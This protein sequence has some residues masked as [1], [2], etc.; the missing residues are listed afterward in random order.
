MRTFIIL[1]AL[2][3]AT[4]SAGSSSGGTWSTSADE[5]T[6]EIFVDS[7]ED[8]GGDSGSGDLS[9]CHDGSEAFRFFMSSWIFF[10]QTHY[11]TWRH[12][13]D[14]LAWSSDFEKGGDDDIYNDA[15]DFS[16]FSGHGNSWGTSFHGT[17]G[18]D[19]ASSSEAQWGNNDVE[20]VALD[21]CQVLSAT[22]R[23]RVQKANVDQGVHYVLGFETNASDVS[24]TGTRY[25]YYLDVGYT[26]ASAWIQATKDGH[27]SWAKGAYVRF[28]SEDC[29]TVSDNARSW[30]CDP[31]SDS[32]TVYN[33]WTL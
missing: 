5:G 22:G 11:D 6:A 1:T 27:G 24:T 19:F 23:P 20:F 4:A 9:M 10:S 15:A 30:S 12:F 21:A 14:G 3:S 8:Y 16:Y 7:V 25:G 31:T 33:V 2:F 32:Y 29:N 13:Q 18:D 17:S 26:V 28:A